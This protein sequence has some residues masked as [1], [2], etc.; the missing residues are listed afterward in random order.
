MLTALGSTEFRDASVPVPGKSE[1]GMDTLVRKMTG[2]VGGLV[3]FI[4]SLNQ[5]DTYL[6]GD[7]I[8]YLQSWQP[9]DSTPIATVTLNYK[10]LK[11]G[12]TPT[13][14]VENERVFTTGGTSQRYADENLGLGRAYRKDLVWTVGDQTPEPGDVYG[15]S[16][17][18]YRTRY[19]TGANLQFTYRAVQS[20]YRYISVGK[21]N[22][23]RFEVVDLPHDPDGN[24]I[25][26]PVLEEVRIALSDG[27]IYGRQ[28]IPFFDLQPVGRERC[29]SHN[30]KNVIGSPYWEATDVV[31]FL[32]EDATI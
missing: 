15:I 3:D 17:A 16:A 8:F 23:P 6:F 20:T 22:G 24:L 21:P 7:I 13:P 4:S 10:G 11:P 12:G 18:F 19:T 5:G 9:D 2:Y 29:I 14:D 25:Y 31:R 1:F 32:L 30:S 28:D 27:T 26:D